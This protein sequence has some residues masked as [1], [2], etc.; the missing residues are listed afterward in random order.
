MNNQNL[1]DAINAINQ[2]AERTN[3][4]TDFFEAVTTGDKSQSVS[5]P[6]DG[7]LIPTVAKQVNDA[8]NDNS[9]QLNSLVSQA[10]SQADRAKSEADR[11]S[12]ISG[13]DTVADAIGLAATP[14][15]DV[16]MPFND[17]LRMLAG[18]GREVKVGDDVVARYATL[19]RNTAG[20]YTNKSLSPVVAASGEPR[21]ERLGI[22][23]EP[24]RTNLSLKNSD[25]SD[26]A[27]TR[28]SVGVSQTSMWGAVFS[29]FTITGTPVGYVNRSSGVALNSNTV[30]CFSLVIKRL[31]GSGDP[32]I[33]FHTDQ[34]GAYQSVT[35]NIASKSVTPSGDRVVACGADELPGGR[36]RLWVAA[37]TIVGA[38]S[39]IRSPYFW[40]SNQAT[41]DA[42][43]I[44]C[45]QVE[46]G[47]FPT[48]FI[49]TPLS[50]SVTRSADR[51]TIP[52]LNNEC[53]EWYSGSDK[54]SPIVTAD[55]IE[56]V[57]P[58]GK[59]HLRNVKGFFTQLTEAQKKGLK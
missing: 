58:A 49:N 13:L 37:R 35:Y 1:T 28:G 9:G 56:L 21:F 19:T 8:F 48:S 38:I 20:S 59:L 26:L 57:P 7:K 29:T 32:A 17:S 10:T 25:P 24:Q 53:S 12:Q 31:S 43:E 18:Y 41:G 51:V 42:W 4:V 22:L 27:P 6:V 55:T 40:P 34:F 2:S 46:A 39:S 45:W 15:P 54:I 16:W 50:A 14:F 52:R 23:A 33:Q 5:S 36:I 30:Y 11:A 47:E 44:G 3:K